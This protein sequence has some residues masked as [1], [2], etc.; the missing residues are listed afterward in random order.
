MFTSI[1]SFTL[2]PDSC[3]VIVDCPLSATRT[4]AADENSVVP[5]SVDLELDEDFFDALRDGEE[6]SQ[7]AYVLPGHDL[8]SPSSQSEIVPDGPN[9]RLVGNA[10]VHR[11][12]PTSAGPCRSRTA[13]TSLTSY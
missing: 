10:W 9:D 3:G 6:G 12:E 5:L 8:N 7:R 4:P 11:R 13:A 2:Q 1:R